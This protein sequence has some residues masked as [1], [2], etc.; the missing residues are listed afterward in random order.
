[1]LSCSAMATHLIKRWDHPG[2]GLF[3]SHVALSRLSACM[4]HT[5]PL[6][7]L[8]CFLALPLFPFII[9][10]LCGSRVIKTSLSSLSGKSKVLALTFC[11]PLWVSLRLCVCVCEREDGKVTVSRSIPNVCSSDHLLLSLTLSQSCSLCFS[12]YLSLMY[13]TETRS[14][15]HTCRVT[16]AYKKLAFKLLLFAC[17]TI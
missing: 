11:L 5:V 6:C 10:K 13:F 17:C 12:L 1:M 4:C 14:P 16:L 9:P 15:F 3:Q 2:W 8:H 7:Y